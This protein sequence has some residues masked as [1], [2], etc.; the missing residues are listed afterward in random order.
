MKEIVEG[1][2]SKLSSTI[3]NSASGREWLRPWSILLF[4]RFEMWCVV[5]AECVAAALV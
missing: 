1:S 3:V 5:A 4:Y 2:M